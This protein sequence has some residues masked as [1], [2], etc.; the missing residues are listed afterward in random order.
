MFR[1]TVVVGC[2]LLLCMVGLWQT[3]AKDPTLPWFQIWTCI[4]SGCG[5]LMVFAALDFLGKLRPHATR[6]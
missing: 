1:W 6:A 2:S 4:G 3:S 5:Y